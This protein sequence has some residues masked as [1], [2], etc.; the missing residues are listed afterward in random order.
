[1]TE[2]GA[3]ADAIP[4]FTDPV[5]KLRTGHVGPHRETEAGRAWRW[6]QPVAASLC[7]K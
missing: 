1:M 4:G 5:C 6:P 2:C 3:R 7:P